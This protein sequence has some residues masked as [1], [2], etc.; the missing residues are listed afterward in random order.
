MKRP[1]IVVILTDDQGYGDLGCMGS[2]DLKTP[3]LDDPAEKRNLADEEP[4]LCKRLKEAALEWRRGIEEKW[5]KEF[6]KNYS[7]T[8]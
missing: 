4:E 7:L 8:R 3:Y 1:N 2:E 5:D 6:A